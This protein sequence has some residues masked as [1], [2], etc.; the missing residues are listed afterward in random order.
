[1]L[2][3]TVLNDRYKLHPGDGWRPIDDLAL[4]DT[5]YEVI[6]ANRFV[7][8]HGGVQTFKALLPPR[9]VIQVMITGIRLVQVDQLT[10]AQH[11]ALGP[12]ERL[13]G[14]DELETMGDRQA[15]FMT[16]MIVDGNARVH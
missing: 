5:V 2:S 10:P 11:A 13:L 7:H 9:R 1:M 4:G 8:T 14:F 6:Q 12:R 16:I 15:W 3:P